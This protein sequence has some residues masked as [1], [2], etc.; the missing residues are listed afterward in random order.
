MLTV[1][2][3]L[4]NKPLSQTRKHLQHKTLLRKQADPSKKHGVRFS[5]TLVLKPMHTHG[6]P[7]RANLPTLPIVLVQSTLQFA[8][9]QATKAQRRSTGTALLF[10]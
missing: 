2:K 5:S 10:L 9:E 8:L 6:R 4:Q 3:R 7:N 1:Q